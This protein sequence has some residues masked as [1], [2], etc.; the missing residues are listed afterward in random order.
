[1]IAYLWIT[2]ATIGTFIVTFTILYAA[3]FLA[4]RR[5][6]DAEIERIVHG[7]TGPVIR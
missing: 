7:D 6:W 4:S 2:L 3:H 5:E 1:M